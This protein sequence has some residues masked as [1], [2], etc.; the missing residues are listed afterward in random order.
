[1]S[2]ITPVLAL[3]AFSMVAVECTA[4]PPEGRQRKRP[5]AAERLGGQRPDPT[6]LVGRMMQ[7]FDQDGDQKLNVE[8]L[9]ALLT[10]LRDRRGAQRPEGAVGEAM[11]RRGAEGK[12]GKGNG[13]EET[14]GGQKPKR[15]QAE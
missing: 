15:P 6:Q 10:S 1:M 13:A 3:M 5:E 8:E 11:R 12:R 9:T 2:R 4:A 14:A 7:Q